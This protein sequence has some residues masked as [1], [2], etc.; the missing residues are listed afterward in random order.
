MMKSSKNKKIY[1]QKNSNTFIILIP[2]CGILRN[3]Y[4]RRAIS[5]KQT[6]SEEYELKLL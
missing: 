6:K 2:D 5:E 1:M 4:P 3:L